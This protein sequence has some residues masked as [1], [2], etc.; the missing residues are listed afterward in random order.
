MNAIRLERRDGIA[1][2]TLN[3][4]AYHNALNRPLLRELS[5]LTEVLREERDTRVVI[6]TG[7][8]EKAFCAGADLKERQTFTE[9]DVRQFIVLIRDTFTRIAELPQPTIAAI[10]GVAFGG[11]MELALA[12]DLRL[13]DEAA[14]MG[15]TE[16][17]LGIIPGAGG[18]QRLPRLVGVAKAKELI[19]MAKR[20]GAAEALQMGL[21]NAISAPGE[22]LSLAWEWAET[23]K[24]NAP[25]ALIQAK[26]AI[27]RGLET[28][29]GEGLLLE[30]K[31]YD[32]LIPTK[33]RL[34]GLA[35]FQEKRKPQYR[36]E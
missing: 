29:M 7:A 17:S 26:W 10:N 15:L 33:D 34:E 16:T 22:V 36:G 3:R 35:A 8:G 30:T 6:F 27:D 32:V 19:L 2:V 9:E 13:M 4:P 24:Q 23:L 28:G 1:L 14:R 21:V 5:Q 25:L 20:F 31:A 12:C 11:G 18:T